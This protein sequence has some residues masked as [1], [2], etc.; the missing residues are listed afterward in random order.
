MS[1]IKVQLAL[2]E[3]SDIKKTILTVPIDTL[4]ISE[5]NPRKNRDPADIEKLAN[6][7]VR[8]GYELTRAMW[9]YRNGDG[10]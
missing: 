6:R 9:A 3:E 10:Y 1:E 8:N 4:E 2:L 7:I 5:F